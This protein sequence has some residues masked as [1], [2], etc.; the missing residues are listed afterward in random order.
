MGLHVKHLNPRRRGW[1]DGSVVRNLRRG[2]RD[3]SEVRNPRRGAGGMAQWLGT[4][5]EGLEGWLS[6][7]KHWLLI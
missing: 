6:G 1:R 7:Q 5:G 2:L 4:Q 3:G